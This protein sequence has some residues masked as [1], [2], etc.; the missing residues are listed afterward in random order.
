MDES[1]L[2]VAT[3]MTFKGCSVK[4]AV[5]NTRPLG[6]PEAASVKDNLG[7]AASLRLHWPEYLME[8]GEMSLYLF[9][10]CSFA[11]LVQHPASPVRH[12]FINGIIRR[13]L[14]GLA[15]GGTLIALIMS[16]W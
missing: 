15:V 13:A 9:C 2:E 6:T 14:M 3:M 5:Y 8:A 4:E 10:T 16:P 12:F 11:T 1:H 7:V